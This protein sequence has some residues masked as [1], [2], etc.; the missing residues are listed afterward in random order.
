MYAAN[1]AGLAG[2]QI[3]LPERIFVVDPPFA[4]FKKVFINPRIVSYYGDDYIMDEGCLSI[5]GLEAPVVRKRDIRVD[6]YDENWEFHS[7]SFSGLKSRVLQHEYDHLEGV[8]WID[9]VD[10]I[11]GMKL[12]KD[13]K[14]ITQRDVDISYP[15]I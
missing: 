13:L 7:E 2:P 5:P 14:K 8:L 12:I 15:Y 1:G 6:Y 3:N 4:D 10:P 11:V 9:R